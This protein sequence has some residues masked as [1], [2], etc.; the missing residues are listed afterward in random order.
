[1][2]APRGATTNGLRSS[3]SVRSVWCLHFRFF[4]T[5]TWRWVQAVQSDRRRR[6]GQPV[7]VSRPTP[8]HLIQ[9]SLAAS[10]V[11][12]LQSTVRRVAFYLMSGVRGLTKFGPARSFSNVRSQPKSGGQ[13]ICRDLLM[14]HFARFQGSIGAL[15]AF[16]DWLRAWSSVGMSLKW[17]MVPSLEQAKQ[18]VGEKL[19]D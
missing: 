13:R 5:S 10:P 17:Y 19:K 6:N 7:H 3:S 1:M 12:S 16:P 14:I 4:H 9:D 15:G 8:W 18:T 11:W 2:A